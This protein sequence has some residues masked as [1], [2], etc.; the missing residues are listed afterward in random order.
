MFEKPLVY[1]GIPVSVPK[2][3]RILESRGISMEDVFAQ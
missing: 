1:E 3:R 2:T